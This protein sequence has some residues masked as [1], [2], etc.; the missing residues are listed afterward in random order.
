M[1]RFE[2]CP[3]DMDI[4]SEFDLSSKPTYVSRQERPLHIQIID[5]PIQFP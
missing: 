2:T 5:R 3:Y 1:G 4:V